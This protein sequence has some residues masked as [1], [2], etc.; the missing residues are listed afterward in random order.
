LPSLNKNCS[1]LALSN[2]KFTSAFNNNVLR[3]AET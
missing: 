1:L 3:M 2:K